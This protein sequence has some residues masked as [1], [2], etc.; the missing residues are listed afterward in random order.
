MKLRLS[1]CIFKSKKN[2]QTY[3]LAIRFNSVYLAV[4]NFIKLIFG[5]KGRNLTPKI[6]GYQITAL[7]LSKYHK[8]ALSYKLTH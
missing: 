7:K 8:A 5:G 4:V 1:S 3:K 6:L 2:P